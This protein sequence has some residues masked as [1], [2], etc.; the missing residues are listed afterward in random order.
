MQYMTMYECLRYDT[1]MLA[2]LILANVTNTFFYLFVFVGLQIIACRY[3]VL[4]TTHGFNGLDKIL[5]FA[6]IFFMG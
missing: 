3:R 5:V 1:G 4:L 2:M 6:S